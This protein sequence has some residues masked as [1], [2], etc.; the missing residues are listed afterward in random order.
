MSIVRNPIRDEQPYTVFSN[1]LLND[2]TLSADAL[3]VLV[4]LLSKPGNWRVLPGPLGKRFGC[5]R[6]KIYRI[7]NELIV[8]GYAQRFQD[9]DGGSFGDQNFLVS[10]EKSP[11]PENPETVNPETVNPHLQ[12]KDS[13]KER[14]DS[15]PAKQ[16]DMPYSEEFEALWKIYPRTRNTSKKKAHDLWRMLNDENRERVRVAVP[17]FA[18]AMRAEGRAEDKIKHFQ[19]FLSEKIYET[20]GAVPGMGTNA[21]QVEWWKTAT[22]EQWIRLLVLWRGDSNWRPAWGPEPGK[23]GCCVPEDL[24]TENEKW[25][26]SRGPMKYRTIPPQRHTVN[27]ELTPTPAHA[28]TPGLA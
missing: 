18:S 27:D 21:A 1:D 8:A 13:T 3:G 26:I 12:K 6:D 25:L 24:L 20:V 19:F 14:K 23:P 7:M 2:E 9:R 11:L 28:I 17:I 22:R 10:N 15:G 16:Q 4:Y 5:G